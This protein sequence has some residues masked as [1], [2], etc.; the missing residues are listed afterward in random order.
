MERGNRHSNF[1]FVDKHCMV[2]FFFFTMATTKRK[3]T[4]VTLQIQYQ[5][6]QEL[7]KGRTCKDVA[8]KFNVPG[9]TLSTWKKNKEKIFEV[10]QGSLL[11]RQR[12]KVGAYE[13]VN[14]ALL[15]WFTSMRG[16]NI[17][18]GNDEPPDDN[19]EESTALVSCPS[20]NEVDEAMEILSKLCLFTTD[21]E[22]DPLVTKLGRKINQRRQQQLRQP[23]IDKFFKC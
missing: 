5:A 13:K 9:S 1:V 15:K 11:K 3:H 23:S 10:F 7:E 6:L 21:T 4:E 18:I 8:A 20:R 16:N 2:K 12:V 22:M 17:P 19:K 14:R